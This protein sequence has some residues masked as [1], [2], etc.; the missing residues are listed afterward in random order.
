MTGRPVLLS[1][2]AAKSC[3]RATHNTYDATIPEQPAEVSDSLQAMFDLGNNHE[4]DVFTAWLATGLDI[5]DLRPADTDKHS[6]IVATVAALDS[7]RH[8]ILGGRLPDDLTGARTGKPDALVCSPDGGY[9]PVDVKAHKILRSGGV[10][11]SIA[12][13]A[14]PGQGQATAGEGLRWDE[15]DLLQL[16]HYWRMLQ[17]SGHAAEQPWGAIIGTEYLIGWYDLTEPAYVTFSRSEGKKTRSALER[18][19]HEHDFRVRVAKVAQQRTLDADLPAPLVQPVGQA[20][21]V[22]CAWASVC[23]ETLPASDVSRELLGTLTVREYLALAGQ[24]ITTVDALADADVDE[25]LAAGFADEHPHL[26][27]LRRRLQKAHTSASLARD[28]VALRF[29]PGAVLD[30]PRAAV[31]I[32]LDMECDR[33]GRVYLWGALVTTNE[34]ST[35]VPFVDVGV[36][37]SASELRLARRCFAWLAVQNDAL[38]YH[39]SPVERTVA[40]RI[41]GQELD[42]LVNTSADPSGW[43]DLHQH[44]KRAFESRAGLGLKVVATI[45]AGFAWREED[46]G[47]R[48]SQDWLD[49]AKAGDAAAL[50]RIL[51]YN[52]DDVRATLAVR[53]WLSDLIEDQ[54]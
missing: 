15:R 51:E 38:V 52:E 46:P 17:A 44:V 16:A 20:E 54:A 53:R 2:Y 4:D 32:D 31:E 7:G 25:L 35:F 41:L 3:A 11:E 19:D 37:D 24:G 36:A 33:E 12:S 1:G 48:Q 6:H 10:P 47:G 9:H 28:G 13:L 29:A 50:Q 30:V 49:G 40:R 45:G 21:C 43:V 22:E 14:A 39:Y 18:Y 23:I 26:R 5:I 8:V 27:G 42:S 34:K